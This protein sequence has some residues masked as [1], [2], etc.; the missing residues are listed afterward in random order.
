M[1]PN[2][3]KLFLDIDGVLNSHEFCDSP[4]FNRI[5]GFI[6]ID[7]EAVARLQSIIDQS[8]CEIVLSST[9]RIA[10]PLEEICKF[11]IRF[12]A[13]DPVPLIDKTPVLNRPRGY[14]I[15]AWIERNGFNGRYC[16]L[17]DGGDFLPHQRLV[18][19]S[20]QD[21]LQDY[22]IDSVVHLLKGEK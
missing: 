6:G 19:T 11:L 20:F 2:L 8:G 5:G 10:H 9:W 7:P 15:T 18:Q 22:H 17:D 4:R 1:N 14:E 16:C 12:G 13:R 3:P 21:G